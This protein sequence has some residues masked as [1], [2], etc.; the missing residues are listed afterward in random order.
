MAR[1]N[2]MDICHD[3]LKVAESGARKTRLVYGANLNFNIVKKYLELL[4]EKGFIE[5]K[6]EHYFT[7]D[8]GHYWMMNYNQLVLP[9]RD[10][11][12]QAETPQL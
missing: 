7:T 6:D 9:M 3:I 11:R 10:I 12:P 5:L 1:R 2:S 4:L 8:R